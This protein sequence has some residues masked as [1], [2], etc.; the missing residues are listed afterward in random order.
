MASSLLSSFPLEVSIHLPLMRLHV[1][2]RAFLCFIQL[3]LEPGSLAN[4]NAWTALYW[5]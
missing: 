5:N 4:L 1:T 2:C 3:H